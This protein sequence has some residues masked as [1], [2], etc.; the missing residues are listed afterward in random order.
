MGRKF[1][2]LCGNGSPIGGDLSQ[3]KRQDAAVPVVFG[4]LRR[5]DSGKRFE[6]G[7]G[8]IGG[9]RFDCHACPAPDYRTLNAARTPDM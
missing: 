1:T 4:F 8:A 7:L 5:I 9:S 6:Y 2:S 3:N